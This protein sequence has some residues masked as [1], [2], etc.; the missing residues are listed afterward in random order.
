[1]K[2]LRLLVAVL[3]LSAP[4]PVAA[5]VNPFKGRQS[6]LTQRD[7]ELLGSSIDRLNQ[8]KGIAVGSKDSWSNPAS[9]S[10]GE[11]TVREIFQD[12]GTTCHRLHHEITVRGRKPPRTYE[13]TWCRMPD[14]RWKIKS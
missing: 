7:S 12:A 9:H 4:L 11:N 5:Q 6:G 1:M 2:T 8:S 3:L 10:Q 13:L 14:G